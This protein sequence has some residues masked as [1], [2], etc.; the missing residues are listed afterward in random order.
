MQ[1]IHRQ[2]SEKSWPFTVDAGLLMCVELLGAPEVYFA[3]GVNEFDEN[4]PDDLKIRI[5]HL[6]KNPFDLAVM[7]FANAD[8]FVEQGD[9]MRRLDMVRPVMEIGEKLCDQPK[10]TILPSGEL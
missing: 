5:L 1:H 4:N 7:N 8:L 10:G 6:A 3:A 2:P 9:P